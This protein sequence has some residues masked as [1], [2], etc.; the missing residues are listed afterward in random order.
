MN[1]L[2]RKSGSEYAGV[3]RWNSKQ[4]SCAPTYDQRTAHI[5]DYDIVQLHMEQEIVQCHDIAAAQEICMDFRHKVD[6]YLE[7]DFRV[8]AFTADTLFPLARH[9]VDPHNTR[10]LTVLGWIDD[11]KIVNA[12]MYPVHMQ[13]NLSD[14]MKRCITLD[15]SG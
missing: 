3:L 9:I 12:T 11:I 13:N 7:S 4:I 10:S 5:W 14:F 2:T 1:I 15:V 6:T 8:N